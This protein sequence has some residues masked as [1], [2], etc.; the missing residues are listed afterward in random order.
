MRFG[1]LLVF[2][3]PNVFEQESTEIPTGI[4]GQAFLSMIFILALLIFA[5]W[6]MRRLSGG[7]SFGNK[8]L[9]ILGGVAL[10]PRERI[11]LIEVGEEC[12]VVGIVPGQIRTLHRLP[13][14]QIQLDVE[15]KNFADWL[16]PLQAKK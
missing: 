3:A 7:K 10:G 8:S 9:K 12:L 6:L 11:V 16:K 4:Y 13:K 2:F 5:A 15:Q 14:N 1:W